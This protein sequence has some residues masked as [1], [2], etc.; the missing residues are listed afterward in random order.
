MYYQCKRPAK[1]QWKAGDWYTHPD[2]YVGLSGKKGIGE[3]QID[4]GND[5]DVSKMV[6]IPKKIISCLFLEKVLIWSEIKAAPSGGGQSSN[7]TPSWWHCNITWVVLFGFY[8]SGVLDTQT[9]DWDISQLRHFIYE[10]VFTGLVVQSWLDKYI[11]ING[12]N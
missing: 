3:N 9:S 6:K 1:G 11:Q 8:K 4:T 5:S 12:Q 2:F 7:T 10:F